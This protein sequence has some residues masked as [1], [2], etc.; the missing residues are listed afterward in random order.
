LYFFVICFSKNSYNLSLS[1]PPLSYKSQP[2]PKLSSKR[3]AYVKGKR[4]R[5]TEILKTK[6]TNTARYNQVH[7]FENKKITKKAKAEARTTMTGN[8]LNTTPRRKTIKQRV[9][10]V[11]S[12][13]SKGIRRVFTG[14]SK[15]QQQPG[16]SRLEKA[17]NTSAANQNSKEDIKS[18]INM[19]NNDETKY[20]INDIFLV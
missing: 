11:T 8:L 15:K 5:P 14:R 20:P 17:G 10:S 9:K 6:R 3:E 7:K 16:T 19:V 2:E 1:I 4:A 13:I 18:L 12:K